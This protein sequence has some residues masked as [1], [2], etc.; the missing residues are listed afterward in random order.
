MSSLNC[1]YIEQRLQGY[2]NNNLFKER[3][4]EQ[5]HCSTSKW[6]AAG[7]KVLCARARG[8]LKTI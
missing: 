5:K 2:K 3:Q 7:F 1:P 6:K 8:V 4:S